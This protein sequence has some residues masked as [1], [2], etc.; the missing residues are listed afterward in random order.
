MKKMENS[1]S[2][3]IPTYNRARFSKLV[4][5]NINIQTYPNILEVIVADD[6]NE[7]L[8]LDVKYKVKYFNVKRMSIGDKRNFLIKQ[9]KGKYCAFMD[10]DD[11]Y[12]DS[13]LSHSIQLLKEKKKKLVGSA[14]MLFYFLDDGKK[15]MMRCNKINLLHEATFVFLRKFNSKFNDSNSGEGMSFLNGNEVFIYESDIKKVMVCLGHKN[16]TINKEIW[17]RNTNIDFNISNHLEII[18]TLNI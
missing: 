4:S 14:D 17:K 10:D 9:A 7:P 16:N 2:I 8:E 3:L 6:G 11:I 12:F 18:S 13:Y 15:D 5:Y 1:I